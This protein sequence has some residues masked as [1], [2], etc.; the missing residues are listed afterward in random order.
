MAA[1]LAEGARVV[2]H[3]K[4]SSGPSAAPCSSTPDEI[5]PVGVG[6]LLARVEHLK[7]LLAAEGL[8][9]A[10]T[11]SSRC[12][13][14]PAGSGWSAAGPAPPSRTSSRTPAGAGRRC[15]FEIREVAVQGPNAVTE[16]QRRAARAGPR[17]GGRRHRHRPR[18]RV[19]RGPAAVQQRGPGPGRRR[20]RVTPVV[21]A[22][23]HEVDTPL[24][25][26]VAD[27]RASTPTDAGQ[28]GR[29]RRRRAARRVDARPGPAAPR[30]R[31]PRRPPSGATL[32]A[33]RS[34]ARAWP[35]RPPWS[36]PA[37]QESTALAR[38]VPPRAGAAS[39]HRAADEVAPP[40]RAR[41]GRCRPLSTL[42]RGYAVVQHARRRASSRTA[43]DVEA[44]RAA[45]GARRPGRLRRAPGRAEPRRRPAPAA[46]GARERPAT[47]PVVGCA[48]GSRR[49]PSPCPT[50]HRD[51]PDIAALTY[52]QARDELVAIVAQLEAGPAQ[53]GGVSM[54]LW[55]RGEALA[56]HCS[57]VAGRR[58]GELDGPPTPSGTDAVEPP[59]RDPRTTVR[60][61]AAGLTGRSALARSA[62][63]S[64]VRRGAGERRGD[65]R[66]WRP[67][68]RSTRLMLHLVAAA[69]HRPGHG[70]PPVSVPVGPAAVGLRGDPAVE[71][72]PWSA[73]SRCTARRVTS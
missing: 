30:G 68:P 21:S 4:P 73:R 63:S 19:A 27:V 5:R 45:A 9:D 56:A 50:R 20:A 44:R 53:P 3:A 42:E 41:S 38:A 69:D 47:A 22:I 15:E 32:A 16:V 17:P 65:A 70:Q 7:R 8:F 62:T 31:A 66:W 58:R 71:S 11:A 49:R 61:Q 59:T 55:Q 46:T 2:V 18:R 24:L 43:D 6:E 67:A 29:A 52:E 40:A 12:R 36:T 23:G 37:A 25:D 57:D 28:A 14:C 54:A 72:R 60:P 10:R 48:G 64:L 51:F 1:P 33:L 34:P 26:L 39:V 13:S 35:T